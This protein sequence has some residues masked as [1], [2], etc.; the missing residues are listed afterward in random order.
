MRI[1]AVTETAAHVHQLERR[2]L[3]T[4]SGARTPAYTAIPRDG[5]EKG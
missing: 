2:G 3:V 1:F 5:T 4:G